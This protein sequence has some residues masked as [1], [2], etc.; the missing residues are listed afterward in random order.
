[1]TKLPPLPAD[2]GPDWGPI[3]D[4]A[5]D[6][7]LAETA[8]GAVVLVGVTYER[9][10]GTVELD[11]QFYGTIERATRTDRVLIALQGRREGQSW[12]M[13]PDIR[14][15]R[16]ADPGEYRLRSTGE[17]VVNPDYTAVRSIRKPVRS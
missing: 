5:W 12:R 1:M 6:D 3:P 7:E 15:L 8:I 13:P 9:H 4:E 10:D 14:A 2:F 17:V 16:P 11:D